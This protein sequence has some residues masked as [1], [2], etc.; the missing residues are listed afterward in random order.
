MPGA[1]AY[2]SPERELSGPATSVEQRLAVPALL[3]LYYGI[4]A[5]MGPTTAT[6]PNRCR[7]ADVLCTQQVKETIFGHPKCACQSTQSRGGVW[8]PLY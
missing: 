6:A 4:D 5:V 7:C 1:I 8:V 3:I 2:S